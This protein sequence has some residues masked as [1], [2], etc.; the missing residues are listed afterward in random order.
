VFGKGVPSSLVGDHIPSVAFVGRAVELRQL[1]G[2]LDAARTEVSGTFVIGGEAGVGKSRLIRQA[3]E[4]YT[5]PPT[6]VLIGCCLD[7]GAPLPFGAVLAALR[8][9]DHLLDG[10][11]ATRFLQ[12]L[13][14][15]LASLLPSPGAGSSADGGSRA[16]LFELIL[17]LFEATSR[18]APLVLVVEDLQWSDRSTRDLLA[19]LIPNLE[20]AAVSFVLSYR[21]DELAA[22]HDLLRYLAQLQRHPSVT[23]LHLQRLGRDELMA[24]VDGTGLAA[25]DA[26][27][28]D[29]IWERSQGNPFYAEELAVLAAQGDLIS[30]PTSLEDMLLGRIRRLSDP[31]Q[32]VLRLAA[33]GGAVVDHQL[34]A[35]VASDLDADQLDAALREA[36]AHNVVVIRGDDGQLR[37]RHALL[38]EVAYADMLPGER[39]EAHAR[40]GRHLRAPAAGAAKKSELAHHLFL[41]GA[42]TEALAAA[43][44]AA[45]AAEQANGYAESRLHLERAIGLWPQVDAEDRPASVELTDLEERAAAAAHLEGES[46]RAV[47]LARSALRRLP[48]GSERA[49][50]LSVRLGDYLVASGMGDEALTVH[51]AV[52]GEIGDEDSLVGAEASGAYARSLLAAARHRESL[53]QGRR[54][55]AMARSVGHLAQEAHALTTIGSNLVLLDQPDVGVADLHKALELA[56]QLGRP[57]EIASGYRNLAATLSGPL[58]RL[59]EALDVALRGVERVVEL[60][61]ERHWGVSLRSIAADTLFRLGRWDDAERYIADALRRS[62]RGV[63]AIELLLARIKIEVGRGRFDD[64]ESDLAAARKL[65]SQAV[66]LVHTVPIET[67]TAGLALWQG[68]LD[69]ARDAVHA[70]L[71]HGRSTDDVWYLAPLVWHG[72][73]VEAETAAQARACS[74]VGELDRAVAA[75]E[76]MRERSLAISRQGRPPGALQAVISAYDH[77][78]AGELARARGAKA[79]EPWALA[80]GTWDDLGHCYPAAYARLRQAEAL[81]SRHGNHREALTLVLFAHQTAGKLGAPPLRALVEQVARSAG[82]DLPASEEDPTARSPASPAEELVSRAGLTRRESQVLDL[83]AEGASNRRIA[84]E[85]FISEKTVSVH[86]SHL[87]AKL[88]VTSRVQAARLLIDARHASTAR[89]PTS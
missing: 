64:A 86:V 47:D 81:V 66:E 63:S 21:S 14:A 32:R 48:V 45:T 18:Q 76:E 88:G 4:V 87:M 24:L 28:H 72:M 19:F 29:K 7:S 56:E 41:A 68:R 67:L 34:L 89:R 69:E 38:R 50:R 6:I 13:R 80:A 75:A 77:L 83:V 2:V 70:G 49:R 42:R 36:V 65:A 27:T 85:L 35:A 23:R 15:Y 26:D 43:L 5:A 25:F 84:T 79:V 37:F 22:G 73:R 8:P 1:G 62:P 40:F 52:V 71:E 16:Q 12:P 53:E 54:A 11:T 61:L 20:G 33:T 74:R 60:G 10:Q 17:A 51:E 55:L 31:A 44:D 57:A 3:L 39:R 58:N 78:C 46:N 59:G 82:L 9:L 30:I